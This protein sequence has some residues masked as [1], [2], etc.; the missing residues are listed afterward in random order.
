MGYFL[1]Q[2]SLRKIRKKD[3][4]KKKGRRQKKI[5][6]EKDFLKYHLDSTNKCNSFLMN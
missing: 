1:L 5:Q 6:K 2:P 3:R 4:N